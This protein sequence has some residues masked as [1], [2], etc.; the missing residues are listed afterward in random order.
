[1]E[2][3]LLESA[4]NQGI[5]TILY[6]FLFVWTLRDSKSREQRYEDREDKY[7]DTISDNQEV[8]KELSK[9]FDVV[10]EIHKDV[11]EIKVEIERRKPA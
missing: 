7:Q 5:W 3:A 11:G 8:I 2:H 10:E 4:A 1:M 9:K 6:V